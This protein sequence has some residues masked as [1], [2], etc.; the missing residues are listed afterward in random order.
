MRY[1]KVSIDLHPNGAKLVG[2]VSALPGE[3]KTTIAVSVAASIAKTG[4]KVLLIDAD[5]RNPSLTRTLGYSAKPGLVNI[6]SENIDYRNV[7]ISDERLRADVITASAKIR[8]SNSVDILSSNVAKELYKKARADYDYVIVD[9]PPILPV[10][11][12]KATAHLFDA[13][14]MV[15]EWGNT[16]VDEITKAMSMSS[17]VSEKILGVV[18][19]KADEAAMRRFEG[20][21]DRRYSYYTEGEENAPASRT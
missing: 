14:V 19:N 13:F 12:V 7:V 6:V 21:S 16:T 9:L 18:L 1:I 8:T 2:F 10:V 4:A 5:L 15:V 17:S 3:G 20:Y 11:D